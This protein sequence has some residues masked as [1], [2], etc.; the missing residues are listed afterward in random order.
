MNRHKIIFHDGEFINSRNSQCSIK[1]QTLHYGNGVFEGIR[2]YKTLEG[3]TAIFK[4]KAHFERLKRSAERMHM[5]FNYSTEELTNIAYLLLEKNEL[6]DAYIRPLVFMGEEMSLAPA[7]TSHLV[8]MAW[9]WE[10]YLGDD[11][12]RVMLSSYQ[13]PNPKAFPMEVKLSGMYANSI[14]ATQEAKQKGFDEAL[15]CDMNGFIA[16]GSGQNFFYEKDGKLYTPPLGNILPG[17]TRATIIDLARENGIEVF[18]QHCK[19][20]TL[21]QADSAFFTGTASEVAGIKSIDNYH[22]PVHWEDSLGYQL[23][24][25]YQQ[26]VRKEN[27]QTYTII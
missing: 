10:K 15:L 17:I 1:S 18:E 14:L 21:Q 26:H 6:K 7:K 24:Q 22:F 2:A 9:A 11:T 25:E 27:F 20:E 5:P 23:Q 19:P 3:S 16:E 8:M 12:C 4:A 13:R